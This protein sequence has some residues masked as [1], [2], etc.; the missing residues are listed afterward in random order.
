MATTYAQISELKPLVGIVASNTDSDTLLQRVLDAAARM[1]DGATRG[2][3][4]EG[5]EAYSV[6]ASATRYYDDDNSGVIPIDDALTVTALTRG[7]TAIDTAYYKLYPYNPGNGPY[8]RIYLRGDVNTPITLGGTWYS[9]PQAGVGLGQIAVTGTWG[10]CAAANRPEAVKN[11]VLNLAAVMYKSQALTM[12]QVLNMV[13]NQ[14]P[15]GIMAANVKDAVKQFSR[16]RATSI[17]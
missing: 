1:F 10:Y 7:G 2:G 11:A 5:A 6:S 3:G 13:S 8:T 9:Y 15:V 12:E 17:V 4:I 14:N 16:D